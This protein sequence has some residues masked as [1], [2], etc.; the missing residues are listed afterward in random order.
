MI[1]IDRNESALANN[2]YKSRANGISHIA[3][4]AGKMEHRIFTVIKQIEDNLECV[5][6]LDPSSAGLPMN[7]TASVRAMRAVRRNVYDA[8]DPNIFLEKATCLES[9]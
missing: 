2:E 5:L 6:I 3:V 9:Q 4:I 7:V 8:C 1:R